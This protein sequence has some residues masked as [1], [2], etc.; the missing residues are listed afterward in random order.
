MR[1][2]REETTVKKALEGVA[3]R[4]SSSK[5]TNEKRLDLLRRQGDLVER[6]EEL[7]Q[8]ARRAGPSTRTTL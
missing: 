8:R 2:S 7:E 6:R 3:D 5:L 4:L 1:S